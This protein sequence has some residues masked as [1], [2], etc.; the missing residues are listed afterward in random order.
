MSGATP[1]DF[2]ALWDYDDPAATET[3]FRA[4][5]PEMEPGSSPHVQLL[6]Q[7]ARAQGL[8]R[9][10]D[11]A[12]TTLDQAQALLDDN[13]PRARVRYLLERGRVYN[14][15]GRPQQA[16]PLFLEAMEAAQAAGLA[17]EAVDA[18]HMMAI[19]APSEEQLA[20]NLKALALAEQAADDRARKWLGS[21]YNNIGWTYHDQG[22]YEKALTYFKAALQERE[23]SGE[24]RNI[25]IAR[26]CVA[27][28]LRSLRRVEEALAIQADLLA[29]YERDGEKSGYVY[30]ELA[31]GNLLLGNEVQ[32]QSYF[33]MAYRE[34]SQDPW[35]A[36]QEPERLQ[37]LHTLGGGDQ[38]IT[39]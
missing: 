1:G 31:E 29:A 35:L 20:W 27:R 38:P 39:N 17:H 16:L 8:Q 4:L 36:E 13:L 11:A 14:S 25:R 6:T 26:W 10:F 37:R 34:L 12:H 18:A 19:A 15:S 9:Q 5:L 30:E 7:I 22:D 21:L 32:A 24:V 3:R 23:A 28:A 33:A 2:D